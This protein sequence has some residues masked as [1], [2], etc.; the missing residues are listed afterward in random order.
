MSGPGRGRGE[1]RMCVCGGCPRVARSGDGVEERRGER[2]R[3]AR[4]GKGESPK[5]G[6]K[7]QVRSEEGSLKR[8]GE[9]EGL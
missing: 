4:S 2:P 3:V 5:G 1:D 6:E 8:R 9:D 7:A